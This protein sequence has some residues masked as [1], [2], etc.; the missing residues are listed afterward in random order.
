MVR[1]RLIGVMVCYGI[2]GDG[3]IGG[4]VGMFSMYLGCWGYSRLGFWLEVNFWAW[5]FEI[6]V[7]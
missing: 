6:V 5:G 1:W 3:F 7:V 2:V 4:W